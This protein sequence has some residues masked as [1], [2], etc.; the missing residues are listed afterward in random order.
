MLGSEALVGS[1]IVLALRL[2]ALFRGEKS[3]CDRCSGLSR[4]FGGGGRWSVQ[5]RKSEMNKNK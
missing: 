5:T 3:T 4:S 2:S 1:I